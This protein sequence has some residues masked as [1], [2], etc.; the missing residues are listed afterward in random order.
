MA[1]ML[2]RA[3]AKWEAMSPAERDIP[4]DQLAKGGLNLRLEQMYPADGLALRVIARD[5]ERPDAKVDWRRNSWNQDFAWFKKDEARRF[6]PAKL[7]PGAQAD[8]PDEL[9]TRLA[10]CHFVDDVRGQTTSFPPKAVESARLNVEVADVQGAAVTLKLSGATRTVQRGRWAI[11]GFE[12]MHKPGKHERGMELKLLGRATWD[13][14]K[15]RFTAFELVAQ[16]TRWGATQYNGR[17]DDEDPAPIGFVLTLGGDRPADRVAPAH[18][19]E[20]GWK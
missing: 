13:T 17:G 11:R 2:E 10:T 3:L 4:D 19:W 20:Y 16:G 14:A 18:I 15:E 6:L 9:I 7:T 5:L 8:L 12:D 1:G